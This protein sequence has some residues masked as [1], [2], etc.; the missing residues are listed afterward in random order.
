TVQARWPR[1]TVDEDHVV[2]F[3]VPVPLR[4]VAQIRH[5]QHA[6]HVVATASGL[7]DGEVPVSG[8]V[9]APE[10][11]VRVRLAAFGDAVGGQLPVPTRVEAA[12]TLLEFVEGVVVDVVVQPQHLRIAFTGDLESRTGG[13]GHV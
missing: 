7:Q 1:L 6:S 9:R 5:V 12:Q 3:A 8:E 4:R 11:V 13:E 10:E 2:P